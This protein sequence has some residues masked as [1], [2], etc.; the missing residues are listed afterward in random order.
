MY[1]SLFQDSR[2]KRNKL[3]S[4]S[5]GGWRTAKKLLA[6]ALRTQG[7]RILGHVVF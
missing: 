7:N 2:V 4:T 6:D 1:V 5:A 3:S